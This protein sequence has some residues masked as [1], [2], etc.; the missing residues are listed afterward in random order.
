MDFNDGTQKRIMVLD[1]PYRTCE[2]F[3][4]YGLDVPSIPY[5]TNQSKYLNITRNS[6][7]NQ[8]TASTITDDWINENI[9]H[10]NL[11][12]N[13]SNQYYTPYRGINTY[14]DPYE[15]HG[16]HAVSWANAT[17]EPPGIGKFKCVV[18]NIQILARI[19]C[20]AAIIDS[21]DPTLKDSKYS[22]N[23][24]SGWTIGTPSDERATQYIA[25]SCTAYNKYENWTIRNNGYVFPYNRSPYQMGIVPILEL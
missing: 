2:V 3:G 25:V 12:S 21:L 19:F 15:Q 22:R 7:T 13:I 16:A 18:P 24:L 8:K 23:K 14:I 17:I 10:D 4:L 1:A 20:D 9:V 5:Y 11:T 6:S